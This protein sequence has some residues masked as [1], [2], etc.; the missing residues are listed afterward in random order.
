M[1]KEIRSDMV[2][3]CDFQKGI[4]GGFT[5]VLEIVFKHFN[6]TILRRS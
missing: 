3:A 5:A 1:K 6:E 4:Y 2:V